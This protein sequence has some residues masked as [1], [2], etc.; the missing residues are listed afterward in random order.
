MALAAGL[1]DHAFPAAA[2]FFF[3]DAVKLVAVDLRGE[4]FEL[5]DMQVADAVMR[6][7]RGI[8]D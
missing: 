4:V 7:L 3:D 8:P 6:L 1:A 2:E 5:R